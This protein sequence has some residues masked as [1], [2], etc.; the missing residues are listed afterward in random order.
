MNDLKD[1]LWELMPAVSLIAGLYLIFTDPIL[2]VPFW[3]AVGF[4]Y[5]REL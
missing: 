2:S 1:F 3:V 4:Y 5:G